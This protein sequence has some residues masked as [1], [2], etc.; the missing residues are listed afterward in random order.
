MDHHFTFHMVWLW[1]RWRRRYGIGGNNDVVKIV[2][3]VVTILDATMAVVMV[4]TT[5]IVVGMVVIEVTAMIATIVVD[6]KERRD[7]PKSINFHEE[8]Y[9]ALRTR[10][11]ADFFNKAQSL[12]NQPSIYYNH[13]KFSEILLE[14]D[15]ET[16]P[17]I[18]DSATLS[19]TPELKNLMLS[20]FDISAE[21]SHICS[22]LL[23]SIKQVHSNYQFIQRALD[24][25]DG[26]SSENFELI[27]FELNSFIFSN[28]P[29]SN[30]KKNDF[31][32]KLINDKHSSVLHHLKSMRKK[33]GRKIK[34]TKYLKKT[35]GI[36]VTACCGIVA[37]TVIV[38]AAH[39]LVA[40][41]M[42]S[43]ILNFPFKHLKKKL[44]SYK[45]SGS[46]SLSEVYDQLDIAAKGTYIL[47]RDFDTMSRLIA[48]LHDE[49]EHNRAMVQFC[50]DRKEDKFS[51]QIVKEL[52]KSDVG[53]RKQVEELEEHVY[54][55]LVTIN[56]ARALT[57]KK[58]L[59]KATTVSDSEE[60][61]E[62]LLLLVTNVN[63]TL[64]LELSLG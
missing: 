15:Q 10:S 54:L 51:L 39:T 63:Y 28:N 34:L 13:N 40:L 56:R 16:I 18:I 55:C 61:L 3:V 20:Y 1:W 7:A 58:I 43:A 57:G 62:L 8:Y 33:V 25:M 22:H 30:L 48:R 6:V 23:K 29:L 2:V 36:C 45:I 49:I 44:Q 17:S 26:D 46:G 31:N 19:K 60:N 12:S 59:S 4:A 32:F 52:K 50:L 21:A 35:S 38:I 64:I 5:V 41:I 47:N 42:G 27:I 11:Y 9:R 37:V 24:I 53:I 14:P